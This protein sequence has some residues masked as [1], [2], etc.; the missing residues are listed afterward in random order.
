MANHKTEVIRKQSTSISKKTPNICYSLIR[1]YTYAYQK[2]FVLENLACFVFL[3]PPIWDS[4][5]RLT[6]GVLLN[7][8]TSFIIV[9]SKISKTEKQLC[10]EQN[11]EKYNGK[12]WR[13][14]KKRSAVKFYYSLQTR[15]SRLPRNRLFDRYFS[16]ILFE[17][18]RAARC[19][20][21]S[22]GCL[23][24]I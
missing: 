12:F 23:Y 18:C 19:R 2:I 1:A 11:V 6:T 15:T 13:N 22:C 7:L 4:L 10:R 5:F 24:K 17:I 21:P 14:T 16:E 20:T 3:L 8:D 9:L